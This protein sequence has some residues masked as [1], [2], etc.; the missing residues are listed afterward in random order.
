MWAGVCEC[1]SGMQILMSLTT[2]KTFMSN[3]DQLLPAKGTNKRPTLT[4]ESCDIQFGQL[5]SCSC[6]PWYI[7]SH[8]ARMLLC[9]W[10][11]VECFQRDHIYHLFTGCHQ[12]WRMPRIAKQPYDWLFNLLMRPSNTNDVTGP[13]KLCVGGCVNAAY[14]SGSVVQLKV[15]PTKPPLIDSFISIRLT[16]PSSL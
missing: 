3:P 14:V 16:M 11:G 5:L 12:F 13:Y 2:N 1:V 9:K 7:V 6:C 10:A 4:I 8:A 15:G